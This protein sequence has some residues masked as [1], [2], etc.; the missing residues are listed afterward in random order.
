MIIVSPPAS[1]SKIHARFTIGFISDAPAQVYGRWYISPPNNT[2]PIIN[3]TRFLFHTGIIDFLTGTGST[4]CS[5]QRESTV[6]GTELAY[7]LTRQL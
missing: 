4:I 1:S 3:N 2:I 5:L 7:L 6:G